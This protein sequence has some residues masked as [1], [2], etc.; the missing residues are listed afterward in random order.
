MELNVWTSSNITSME[1]DENAHV[2]EV[3]VDRGGGTGPGFGERILKPR[4]IV[5]AIGLA[6]GVPNVPEFKGKVYSSSLSFD[7][8]D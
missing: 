1:Y 5:F 2:W 4:R 6:G 8:G 7:Y 3:N